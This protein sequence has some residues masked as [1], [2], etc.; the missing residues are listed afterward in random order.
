LLRSKLLGEF[1]DSYDLDAR[2]LLGSRPLASCFHCCKNLGKI[3]LFWH[4]ADCKFLVSPNSAVL[5]L[6][7]VQLFGGLGS[8]SEVLSTL[9]E[10]S[11]RIL[12]FV[13]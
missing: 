5:Q 4:L 6:R 2:F 11:V 3:G 12:P 1:C 13:G 7:G 9:V 10:L 8:L